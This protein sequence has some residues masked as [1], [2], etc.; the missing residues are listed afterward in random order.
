MEFREASPKLPTKEETE[1]LYARYDQALEFLQ[2]RVWELRRLAEV[3]SGSHAPMPNL[4]DFGR[5][6]VLIENLESAHGMLGGKIQELKGLVDEF[7]R[8]KAKFEARSPD[9]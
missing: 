6:D 1:E 7:H 8:V 4:E 3:L 5:I 9:A 2:D